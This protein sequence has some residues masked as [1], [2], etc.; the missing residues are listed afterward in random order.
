MERILIT[1][2]NGFVGSALAQRLLQ[3]GYS[4]TCLVRPSANRALLNLRLHGNTGCIVPVDYDDTA[5]LQ[6]LV[7]DHDAVAHCAALTRA[8]TEDEFLRANV[9]LTRTFVRLVNASPRCGH[10]L[11]LSSQ[12]AA[13]ESATCC[14]EDD[15]CNP[16]SMYGASKLEAESVVSSS[17][18]KAWTIVRPASVFGPG[19]RD[20]LVLF[21]QIKRH[22]LPISG[23]RGR[24]LSLIYID[25]LCR[26]LQLCLEQDAARGEIFFACNEHAC[27]Q[28]ELLF[29]IE[30]AVGAWAFKV[31]IPP[32][33]AYVAAVVS[34]LMAK[35]SGKTPLL[36]R[37]RVKE[38][39][40]GCWTCSGQK[41]AR[42]L[43]FTPTHPLREALRETAA[44]YREQHWL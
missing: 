18:R 31:P 25:D 1:G 28:Q 29:G 3:A 40:G 24:L 2:A 8:L 37:E 39:S 7:N 5:A 27:T 14:A 16:V 21:R 26:L 23:Q 38:F 11:F 12:A 20:F 22:I 17:C 34:E 44:W 6:R 42:L 9:Q 32:R 30:L 36:N 13:G 35:K 4:V 19:D 41:A 15:D 10:L 33:V 43:S